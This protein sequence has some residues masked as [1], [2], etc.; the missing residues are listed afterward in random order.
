MLQLIT[1]SNSCLVISLRAPSLRKR[2]PPRLNSTALGGGGA[3]AGPTEAAASI[4]EGIP[5]LPGESGGGELT[6]PTAEA[7]R[8]GGCNVRP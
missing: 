1:N 7:C 3:W 4:S 5:A 2:A 6:K 8:K